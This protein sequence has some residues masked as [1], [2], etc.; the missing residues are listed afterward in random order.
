MDRGY[1]G[2]RIMNKIAF[3]HEEV[4]RLRN[5]EP[6]MP[7][8]CEIDPSNG[9][10]LSCFFCI[11]GDNKND[12]MMDLDF[13]HK[14]LRELKAGGTKSITFTGGGEPTLNPDFNAMAALA[15]SNGFKLGLVTNGLLLNTVYTSLFEFIRVSLDAGSP[16]VYL[17]I[18]GT[19]G[20]DKVMEN[21]QAVRSQCKALGLSYVIDGQPP[22]DIAE[23]ESWAEYL[24]VDYIQFKPENGCYLEKPDLHSPV[25]LWTE[26]E[27]DWSEFA[28]IIAGLIGIV[29]AD[30][31]Y[32]FCCQ[33]RYDPEFTIAD[34]H[35]ESLNMAVAKR[36]AMQKSV[37]RSDCVSCRYSSYAES[38]IELQE[39]KNIFLK[40]KEFL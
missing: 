25:S 28:C 37:D 12:T 30:G 4:D 35:T 38:Y 5:G 32:V 21:I 15:H 14:L 22:G 11:S 23:A 39:S 40:H 33:H 31:R 27:K 29:T 8:S 10:Q 34:L 13:F 9:C 18:K 1:I 24:E 2:G 16:E 20:F 3:Y 17:A 7:V 36:I 19:L 26:R 6:V